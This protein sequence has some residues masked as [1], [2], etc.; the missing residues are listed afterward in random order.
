[1]NNERFTI[2]ELLFNP[3]DIGMK[4][5]GLSE[6]IVDSVQA[7]HA[8]IQPHLYNNIVLIG[9]NSLMTGFRDR[10]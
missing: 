10:M 3:S 8:D 6:A 5:M 7:C 2:P 1:L 4:E 9:G